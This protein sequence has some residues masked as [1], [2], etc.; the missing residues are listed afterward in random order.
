MKCNLTINETL[1]TCMLT[2][3]YNLQ[4]SPNSLSANTNLLVPTLNLV[5]VDCL[6]SKYKSFTLSNKC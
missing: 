2:K 6:P 5:I 4:S 3:N 1:K